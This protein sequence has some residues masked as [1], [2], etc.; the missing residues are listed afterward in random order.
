[1]LR[2]VELHILLGV[3]DRPRHGYAILQ[4][5]EERTGGHPGFE[6]PTLYRA[7]RRLREE[8]LIE[9]AEPSEPDPDERRDYWRATELGREAL[10]AELSRMEV[11]VT[12]GRERMGEAAAGDGR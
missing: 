9:P 4:E 2:S 12:V 3:V 8:G 7:L 1:M 10:R 11:F 6:I 5:A